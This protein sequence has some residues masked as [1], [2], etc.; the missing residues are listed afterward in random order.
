[1]KPIFRRGLGLLLFAGC[2]AVWV[3]A[4]QMSV[5]ERRQRTCQGK[6]SLDVTITD[7]LE[8]QFVGKADVAGWLEKE[9]RA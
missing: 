5:R 1:M 4:S 7:S 2:I 8:R 6:G 9:Y 3:V